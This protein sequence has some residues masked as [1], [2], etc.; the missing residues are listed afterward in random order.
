MRVVELNSPLF[1][2]AK[3]EAKMNKIISIR[4][5]GLLM[6]TYGILTGISVFLPQGTAAASIPSAPMPAPLFVMALVAAGVVLV[7]YGSLGLLGLLCARKLALPE[8]W[9]A[10]ISNRQ[11]FMVPALAGLAVGVILILGDMVFSPINGLGHFPHPP[12]PTSI[13]AA[14]AAGIGEEVLFRLFFISF[15]TWLISRVILRG[16]AQDLTYAVVSVFS[17]A[18][19][20]LSHLPS[21]MYLQQWTSI[22]QVPPILL[23][24]LLALNGLMAL[25]AAFF[26]RK[27]GFL[28]PVGV[29]FWADVVWHVI[30]GVV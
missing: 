7:A 26:F 25:V 22:A 8:I 30:W 6:L 16:R 15:W 18:A 13:V 4:I 20:G 27:Y 21:L 19:F 24:E 9:D 10:A 29:H 5:F 3:S 17:A 2:A 11:R 28:A 1:S 23:L 12:F 14:L